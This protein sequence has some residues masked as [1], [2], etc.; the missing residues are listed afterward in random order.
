MP[1]YNRVLHSFMEM[2][3]NGK[4]DGDGALVRST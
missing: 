2:I 4:I 3:D 1:S